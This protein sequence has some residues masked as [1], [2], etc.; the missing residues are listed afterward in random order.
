M[1]RTQLAKKS[2]RRSKR[3]TCPSW[4]VDLAGIWK[5]ADGAAT[6]V[7]AVSISARTVSWAASLSNHPK[8]CLPERQQ[9]Q[10]KRCDSNARKI[11][12]SGIRKQLI[13][14]GD[15]RMNALQ[16][17]GYHDQTRCNLPAGF[18]R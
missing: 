8:T 17:G 2:A 9:R 12:A 11:T 16:N 14:D 18:Y 7:E 10:Q 15:M 1:H 5:S 6:A 13:S 3:G 4:S